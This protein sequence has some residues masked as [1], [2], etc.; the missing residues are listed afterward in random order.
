[1][2]LP[3]MLPM[4]QSMTGSVSAAAFW[5]PVLDTK[6]PPTQQCRIDGTIFVPKNAAL[7]E[8]GKKFPILATKLASKTATEILSQLASQ[9]GALLGYQ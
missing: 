7:P 3:I 5:V 8:G 2:Y 1:M 9:T 4:G 6:M